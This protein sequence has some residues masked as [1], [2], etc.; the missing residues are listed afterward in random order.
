MC[1]PLAKTHKKSQ[2]TPYPGVF[3]S[4]KNAHR[5]RFAIFELSR[6]EQDEETGF[7][8]YGAR[9]LNPKTSMW[10]SADPAVGDY[11]PRAP[12]DDEAKKHN[13]NL[14]GMGGV[15]N[16]VNMHVY[17][18]AGNN[19]VKYV[20]PDGR[21]SYLLTWTTS[22]SGVGHSGFAVDNY[23]LVDG[24]L[25][26]NGTVTDYDMWPASEVNPSNVTENV[27]AY[28]GVRTLSKGE[29]FTTDPSL[30]E[31]GKKPNGIIAFNTNAAQDMKIKNKLGQFL[32]SSNLY[33]GFTR[34]CSDMAR[35]GVMLSGG[36]RGW[37][38]QENYLIFNFTTPNMLFKDAMNM[39][40]AK[41]MISPGNTVNYEFSTKIDR[42]KGK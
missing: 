42:A 3:L 34:N 9:Y 33:N 8:Y 35:E 27:E 12:I 7:Y 10:I 37:V 40:N 29:L 4:Q 18:Y 30:L 38:G 16:Y 15:Y 19:P 17:H 14:P 39:P 5:E 6:K 26:P 11:V 31:R 41:I 20:D 28:Y 32:L 2:T 23:D 36:V 1:C 13:Q 22:D 21:E 24:E 25:V